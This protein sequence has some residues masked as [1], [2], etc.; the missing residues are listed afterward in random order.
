MHQDIEKFYLFY[1]TPYQN[2]KQIP[3][4]S[5][6]L[7]AL[8]ASAVKFLSPVQVKQKAPAFTS[9]KKKARQGFLPTGLDFI[10]S[11]P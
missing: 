7:C 4:F 11:S 3:F 2:S 8:R 10:Y 6:F 1:I 9:P 5:A